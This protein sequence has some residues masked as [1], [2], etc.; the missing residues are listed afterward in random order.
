MIKTKRNSFLIV[1]Y[2]KI[3]EEQKEIIFN[4]KPYKAFYPNF[5]NEINHNYFN[6]K[7]R[8]GVRIIEMDED[9]YVQLT[10]NLFNLKFESNK[11]IRLYDILKAIE[12]TPPERGD[13]YDSCSFSSQLIRLING[14]LDYNKEFNKKKLSFIPEELLN[15]LK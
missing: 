12:E 3:D 4:G 1:E 14:K 11:Y 13:Y 5:S 10:K 6:A 2:G 9:S 15:K 8:E 7:N